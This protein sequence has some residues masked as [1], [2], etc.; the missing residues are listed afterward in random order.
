MRFLHKLSFLE[1]E[2]TGSFSLCIM[3]PRPVTTPVILSLSSQ[4][5]SFL[6]CDGG[7]V[8]EVGWGSLAEAAQVEGRIS[9]QPVGSPP[10]NET[11]DATRCHPSWLKRGSAHLCLA[12]YSP[13]PLG[14]FLKTQY[15]YENLTYA[16][17]DLIQG[18]QSPS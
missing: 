10:A 11:Q 15:S 13:R 6:D 4:S 7:E 12:C 8:H 5:L 18:I 17:I 9:L 14:P 2:Q 1:A 16:S 3:H